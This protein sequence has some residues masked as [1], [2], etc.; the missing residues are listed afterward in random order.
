MVVISGIEMI[1]NGL[2]DE[3]AGISFEEFFSIL[4]IQV[5]G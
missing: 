5:L 3:D 4:K 2:F 1:S